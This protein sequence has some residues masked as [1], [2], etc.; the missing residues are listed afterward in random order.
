M[1]QCLPLEFKRPLAF[2]GRYALEI[3][4]AHS[5]AAAAVRVLLLHSGISSLSIHLTA[6]FFAGLLVP[7]ALGCLA[8]SYAPF[9]FAVKV[10]G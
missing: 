3:Y 8:R 4:L 5:I 10:R 9:V 7:L 1:A 6:G 2:L